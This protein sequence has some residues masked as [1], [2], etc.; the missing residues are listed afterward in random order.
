MN[1]FSDI[2]EAVFP[3]PYRFWRAIFSKRYRVS[4]LELYRTQSLGWVVVDVLVSGFFWLTE[5]LALLAVLYFL[6]SWLV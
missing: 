2:I 6:F 3:Y 1:D 5:L 4:M